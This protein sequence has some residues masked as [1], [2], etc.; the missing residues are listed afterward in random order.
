MPLILVLFLMRRIT[1]W[2]ASA[3]RS[4]TALRVL[5]TGKRRLFADERWICSK[6]LLRFARDGLRNLE[7]RNRDIPF[8]QWPRQDQDKAKSLLQLLDGIGDEVYFASGAYDSK[9][10]GEPG[11]VR[12]VKPES[13]RFYREAAVILDELAETG[14]PSVAHHLVE[15]LEFFIPLDPRGVFLRI[16]HILRA[17]QQGGY[18]YESLAADRIVKLVERY[19]ADYRALLREDS[20]CRQILIEILDTFVQAG[21]PSALRFTY[22]LEEIFR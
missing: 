20:E 6:R 10:Q 21:W 15:T 4:R 5:L 9:R 11:A 3:R 2:P 1:S 12:A 13:E 18:Q 17:G 22:R 7:Q 19:L 16:G 14:L 8:N